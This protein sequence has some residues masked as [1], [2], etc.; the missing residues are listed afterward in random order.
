MDGFYYTQKRDRITNFKIG[1]PKI[2]CCAKEYAKSKK[3]VPGPNHYK[4][5][6][7]AY[8]KLSQ[9]PL[10]CRVYRH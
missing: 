5:D 7:S 10:A 4:F 1:N 8:A 9:S 2:E 6:M 3:W